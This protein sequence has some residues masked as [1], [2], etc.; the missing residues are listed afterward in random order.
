MI[1]NAQ[2][3]NSCYMLSHIIVDIA[4]K[5]SHMSERFECQHH[6]VSLWLFMPLL[7]NVHL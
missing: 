3:N 5:Q 2:M 1:T 7:S 6:G 4:E